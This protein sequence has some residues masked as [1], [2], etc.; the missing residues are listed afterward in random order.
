MLGVRIEGYHA[1]EVLYYQASEFDDLLT[2]IPPGVAL[3]DPRAEALIAEGGPA[4]RLWDMICDIEPRP[5]SH[6]I[7]PVAAGKLLARKRPHL[8]PVSDSRV[9]K[10]L[11]RPR[12]DNR[13]WH[14]LRDQLISDQKLVREL[15]SVR[16]RAGAG[17]MSLLRVFDV[18]CWM[19]SW[20]G[21]H[22]PCGQ[23]MPDQLGKA[24]VP[25]SAIWHVHWKQDRHLPAELRPDNHHR[26][27]PPRTTEGCPKR[28]SLPRSV[29]ISPDASV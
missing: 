3:L 11:N 10:V 22:G 9:K 23:E 8:L 19:F 14:D 6:R 13:W 18:M 7:G 20:E 5:D 29:T 17:H 24:T 16:H 21:E 27:L 2:R 25:V 4:W 1:L 15:E 12:A 28:A 26:S